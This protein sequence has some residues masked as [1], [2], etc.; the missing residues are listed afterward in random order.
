MVREIYSISVEESEGFVLIRL[1]GNGFLYN[2]ARKIVGTLI[3]AGHGE[4]N[5]YS[6]PEIIAS[7]DR[8]KALYMAESCG[9]YLESIEY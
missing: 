9:L 1:S 5:P 8:S 4:M 7:N 6:I 3:A 2:M